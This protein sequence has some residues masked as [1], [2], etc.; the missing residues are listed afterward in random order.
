VL[1]VCVG[2]GKVEVLLSPKNHRYDWIPEP[3][4]EKFTVNGLL[5]WKLLS[6]TKFARGF[7]NTVY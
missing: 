7:G 3:G 2:L 5:H 4:L 1:Y 6:A